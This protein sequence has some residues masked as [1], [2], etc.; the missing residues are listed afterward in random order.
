MV[1]SLFA[2]VSRIILPRAAFLPLGDYFYVSIRKAAH[3]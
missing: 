1:R 2:F 3:A